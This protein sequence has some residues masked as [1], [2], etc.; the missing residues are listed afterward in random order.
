MEFSDL[1]FFILFCFGFFACF[2]VGGGD[3]I[4][5]HPVSASCWYMK[6]DQEMFVIPMH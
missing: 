2:L 4:S 3:V 6:I 5:M 1:V